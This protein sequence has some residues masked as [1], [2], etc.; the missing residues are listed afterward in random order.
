MAEPPT[1]DATHTPAP[2]TPASMPRPTLTRSS[3]PP[4]D[5]KQSADLGSSPLSSCSSREEDHDEKAAS[6][7]SGNSSVGDPSYGGDGDSD[8]QD[9]EDSE[10]E[11]MLERGSEAGGLRET[12][13]WNDETTALLREAAYKLPNLGR[14]H[15]T[16]QG[17]SYGR[18]GLIGEFIR[19]R[20]GIARDRFQVCYR[21]Q[22]LIKAAKDDLTE[23]AKLRGA[24]VSRNDLRGREWTTF[25]GPDLF[26]RTK[27]KLSKARD[28]DE[29]SREL[30][31]PVKRKKHSKSTNSST[32]SAAPSQHKKPSH[33][34][35]YSDDT[36]AAS[37]SST[38]RKRVKEDDEAA[39]RHF[40]PRPFPL[41]ASD[42]RRFTPGT[43]FGSSFFVPSMPASYPS[44]SYSLFPPP[45]VLASTF[46][47][48]QP[49]LSP[50]IS[51][52]TAAFIAPLLTSLL[53]ATSPNRDP[54]SLVHALLNSGLSTSSDLVD[55]FSLDN[56]TFEL[57]L[58]EFGKR[59]GVGPLDLAWVRK[60]FEKARKEVAG[61]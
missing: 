53:S 17:A 12:D 59:N 4:A 24:T 14:R 3:P 9:E 19:R 36:T 40:K 35:P 16:V 25:L 54:S 18:N 44:S 31:P 45:S 58:E 48:P 32:S 8:S 5:P 52:P 26:P 51:P 42:S 29:T 23:I 38:S 33:R 39:T 13:L 6:S 21:L 1:K 41:L 22:A 20:T 43:L 60:A 49:E 2:P 30:P 46:S 7:D 10:E 56:S 34:K 47:I 27:P 50:T 11:G 57:F 55:F 61:M 15:Y 28:D 37:S